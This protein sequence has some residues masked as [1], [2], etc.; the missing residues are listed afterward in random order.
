LREV[1]QGITSHVQAY[2][3]ET[4][5][6]VVR[7]RQLVNA[8]PEDYVAYHTS[9]N[10]KNL[11]PD[12]DKFYAW[13]LKSNKLWKSKFIFV[14]GEE[15]V[16][17]RMFE[18]VSF[19]WNLAAQKYAVYGL[20]RTGFLASRLMLGFEGAIRNHP[21]NTKDE[22]TS[23]SIYEVMNIT[24][25]AAQAEVHARYALKQQGIL[26]YVALKTAARFPDVGVRFLYNT[27]NEVRGRYGRDVRDKRKPRMYDTPTIR[28]GS[29]ENVRGA[30]SIPGTNMKRRAR[31]DR[32]KRARVARINKQFGGQ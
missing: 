18:A 3:V 11:Y 25:Y 19:A 1:R 6:Y 4:S 15:E 29:P 7:T 30:H 22:V 28:I 2:K 17:T 32:V 14:G 26:Y 9:K 20:K 21:I 5:Q 12:P 27:V 31:A 16:S 23:D 10:R 13:M 8:F 24:A